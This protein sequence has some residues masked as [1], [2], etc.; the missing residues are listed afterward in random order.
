MKIKQSEFSKKYI[1]DLEA[2]MPRIIDAFC[3]FF[4][5]K[6]RVQFEQKIQD[7]YFAFTGQNAGV[8]SAMAVKQ[9]KDNSQGQYELMD[10]FVVSRLNLMDAKVQSSTGFSFTEEELDRYLQN[11]LVSLDSLTHLQK[12]GFFEGV[13]EQDKNIVIDAL[14]QDDPYYGA[15]LFVVS[16]DDY[17]EVKYVIHIPIGSLCPEEV[18]RL[19]IHELLHKI[20][21]FFERRNTTIFQ[22][23]DKVNICGLG[24]PYVVENAK[25]Y[26]PFGKEKMLWMDAFNEVFNDYYA[27]QITQSLIEQGMSMFSLN[28]DIMDTQY[29]TPLDFIKPLFDHFEAFFKECFISGDVMR[30]ISK[31]GTEEFFRLAEACY[32]LIHTSLEEVQEEIAKVVAKAGGVKEVVFTKEQLVD[33]PYFKAGFTIEEISQELINKDKNNEPK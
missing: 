22:N 21:S 2:E 31:F 14:K 26:F 7:C 13:A 6:Y 3:D 10:A 4:G 30:V 24:I 1:V 19:V 8:L 27:I 9:I 33:V 20:S 5:D 28:P 32:I 23:Y 29:Q 15:T 18:D 12:V 16:L 11:K 17:S 25:F